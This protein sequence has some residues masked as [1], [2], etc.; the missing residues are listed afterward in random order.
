CWCPCKRTGNRP[1]F[2]KTMIVLTRQIRKKNSIVKFDKKIKNKIQ[3]ALVNPV[4]LIFLNF[5][6]ISEY[7]RYR[8]QNQ[9]KNYKTEFSNKELLNGYYLNKKSKQIQ[10]LSEKTYMVKSGTNI[11]LTRDE[12]KQYTSKLEL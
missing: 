12:C 8:R 5:V 10:N 11:N 7:P 6:E 9:N 3:S 2:S 4:K 1:K